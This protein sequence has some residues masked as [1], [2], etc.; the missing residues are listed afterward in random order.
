MASSRIVPLS[1]LAGTAAGRHRRHQEHEPLRRLRPRGKRARVDL[2][3]ER[4]RALTRFIL[5][6]GC[7]R[8]RLRVRR[9]VRAAAVRPLADERLPLHPLPRKQDPNLRSAAARHRPAAPG[10]PAPR[11]PF[12]D[13]V[14]AQYLRQFAYDRRR[15]WTRRSRRRRRRRPACARRSRSTPPTAASGCWPTCSCRRRESRR[16]RSSWSSRFRG[17]QHALERV[18]RTGPRGLPD[19]RAAAPSSSRSTRGPTSAAASFTRTTP[20]ETTAYKDSRDHVGQGPARG[21]STTSKR[22][23]TSTPRRLAYYGLEL[24]RR[25][26]GRSCRPWSRASRRTCSTSPGLDFQRALPEVDQINYVTRVD[27]ADPDPERRAGLLLPGRRRRS[28]R[29]SSCSARRRRTRSGSCFPGGHSV[30]RTEMIKES[31]EWLTATWP[32][33]RLAASRFRYRSNQA[34]IALAF[35]ARLRRPSRE[36]AVRRARHLHECGRTPPQLQAPGSTARSPLTGV[37]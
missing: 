18:A 35:A 15:L 11:S 9:L 6:G 19:A 21:R 26:W 23:R 5:G 37:R 8:P 34:R 36:A 1:N 17:D 25:L 16:I 28:A 14:F 32:G 3:R 12:R 20:S 31:L 30:P 10:L 2:E 7:E 24:G 22:A 29:C 27:A 4:R 33:G 13:A